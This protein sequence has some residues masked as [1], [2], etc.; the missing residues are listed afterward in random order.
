M[1]YGRQE[2]TQ[3]YCNRGDRL[4]ID[5]TNTDLKHI[6]GPFWVLFALYTVLDAV[7]ALILNW[8]R[9]LVVARVWTKGV[10]ELP[11]P[12]RVANI[13]NAIDFIVIHD[14][15]QKSMGFEEV[16]ATLATFIYVRKE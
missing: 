16:S 7:Q 12:Q 15:M 10:A 6:F 9:F 2:Y 5:K 11:S 4:L 14:H 8:Q 13:P 3:K 1:S